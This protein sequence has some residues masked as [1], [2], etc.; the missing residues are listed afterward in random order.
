MNLLNHN[1]VWQAQ[2]L[3]DGFSFDNGVISGTPTTRANYSVPVTVSNSLGSSSKNILIRAKYRDDVTILQNGSVLETETIRLPALIASIQD[4]TAQSKYNCTTTQMLIDIIHPI[5]GAVILDVPLNFCSFR[6]VTLEDSSAKTGLIL[7]FARTLWKG[8]AP[9]STNGFN[10]WKYSQLRKWLNASGS[11]WFTSSYTADILTPHEDS[12]TD[13]KAVGFLSCLPSALAD[14]LVPIKVITQA[15]FDD[16]NED[17]AIDDPDYVD[18][19]D[20]DITYDKVFVPSLSEMAISTGNNEN[21]PDSNFEGTAWEYYSALSSGAA[22]AQDLN[23][24]SC[25]IITRSAVI[26]GTTQTICVN[27]SLQPFVSVPYN[28]EASPA[29]AFVIA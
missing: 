25:S 2:N 23:S 8:L 5:T 21:F 3:P 19:H 4:G 28:S 20:A 27:S 6:T 10:R 29:P 7:Q 15:F 26:N 12:Y 1:N 13:A 22:I 24:N 9:F 16:N 11:G 14:A 17:S 18:S